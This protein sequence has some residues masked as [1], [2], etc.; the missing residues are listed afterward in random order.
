MF[1]KKFSLCGKHLCGAEMQGVGPFLLRGEFAGT[2]TS[3]F[4]RKAAQLSTRARMEGDCAW[5]TE[6]QLR[7]A[8]GW[9][10]VITI[11]IKYLPMNDAACAILF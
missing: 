9:C 4:G 10:T 11:T 1:L 2:D 6:D 5:S 7:C 8:P 3:T